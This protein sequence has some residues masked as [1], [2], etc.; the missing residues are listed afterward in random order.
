VLADGIEVVAASLENGLLNIDLKRP[1]PAAR[2][3]TIA[4]A[5]PAAE[6]RAIEVGGRDDPR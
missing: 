6:G 1:V 3:R 2:V 4:I 5:T